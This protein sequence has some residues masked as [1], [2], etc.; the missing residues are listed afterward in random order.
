MRRPWTIRPF[1]ICGAMPLKSPNNPSFSTMKRITS[2]KLL[3]G[4][5]F[6]DGGGL[7]CSP[8]LATM[9][10]WVAIVAS[11]F[12]IAPRTVWKLVG[13]TAEVMVDTYGRLPMV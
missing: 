7:D 12:D 10:G 8:T 1:E 13:K 6:R 4:F 11:D 3:K 2:M 9:S 5:P